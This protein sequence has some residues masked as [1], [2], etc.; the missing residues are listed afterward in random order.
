LNEKIE[1]RN[2]ELHKLRKTIVGTV[3][4][5]THFREK[6]DFIKKVKKV[7]ASEKEKLV[8]VE[9]EEKTKLTV[10]KKKRDLYR[11]DNMKRR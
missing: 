5:L 3:E 8:K 9:N 2:E 7:K 4:I 1:E 11:T 10:L 6:L